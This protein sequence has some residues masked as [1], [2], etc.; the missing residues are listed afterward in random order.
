V[1]GES[2]ALA[3]V[4]NAGGTG[5]LSGGGAQLGNALGDSTFSAVSIDKV[6]VGYTLSANDG[7]LSATSGPFTII[8]GAA[9][10][11]VFVTQPTNLQA[12]MSTSAGISVEDSFGNVET[13]DITTQ[14]TLSVNACGTSVL[15][16][17]T[18]NAGVAQFPNLRFYTATPPGTL[19]L[20]ASSDSALSADSDTFVVQANP[21]KIFWDGFETCVP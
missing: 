15:G 20:H 2:V 17:T 21:G 18:V 19:Q 16:V 10:Q 9:T 8:P 13:S 11:L 6:G 3:I 5:I 7:A 1:A 12:G 4:N 14:I